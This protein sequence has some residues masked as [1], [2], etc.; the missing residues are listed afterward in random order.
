MIKTTTITSMNRRFMKLCITVLY[1]VLTLPLLSRYTNGPEVNTLLCN[2]I[3]TPHTLN[4][5]MNLFMRY[6]ARLL[7]VYLPQST[8]SSKTYTDGVF[9][10]NINLSIGQQ[11]HTISEE[12]SNTSQS[13][14]RECRQETFCAIVLIK[15]TSPFRTALQ[16]SIIR[17]CSHAYNWVYTTKK[18]AHQCEQPITGYICC[19]SSRICRPE[20]PFSWFIC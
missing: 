15:L 12:P 16:G 8:R 20:P 9:R 13:S 4:L 6:Y 2:F 17:S 1:I 10:K 11:G 3:C 19:S 7:H 18:N 5:I 14:K